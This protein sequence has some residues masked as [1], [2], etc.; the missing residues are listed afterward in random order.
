MILELDNSIYIENHYF[1]NILI[2]QEHKW[3][4][5]LFVNQKRIKRQDILLYNIKCMSNN[6]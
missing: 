1:P 3:M 2:L 6:D 5:N 4:L